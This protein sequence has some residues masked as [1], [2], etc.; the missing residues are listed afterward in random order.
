MKKL[1]LG[2]PLHSVVATQM[3]H[4]QGVYDINKQIGSRSQI[5]D[6]YK[7][8]NTLLNVSLLQYHNVLYYVQPFLTILHSSVCVLAAVICAEYRKCWRAAAFGF[9]ES[10]Y[11]L[12]VSSHLLSSA[13]RSVM[14]FPFCCLC[15]VIR[16][17]SL[18]PMVE[19]CCLMAVIRS[20]RKGWGE[21]GTAMI[22][23]K[24]KVLLIRF[25]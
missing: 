12:L 13:S 4:W 21:N 7:C 14:T 19:M 9:W 17:H 2:H 8:R 22:L 25:Y 6:P 23:N 5:C 16:A 18:T 10:Q 3:I 11:F 24:F 20:V 1:T 15:A